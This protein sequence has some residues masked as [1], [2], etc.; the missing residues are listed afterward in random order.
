[1]LGNE[2]TSD[3]QKIF[4]EELSNVFDNMYLANTQNRLRELDN[5]NDVDCKRWPWELV[6]N[7]KDSNSGQTDRKGVDIE[8]DIDDNNNSYTFRHNGSP[9]NVKSL[10]ALMYK[11]SSGKRNDSE[12]TGRFGTG[13]LTTHALSKIVDIKGDI[14]LKNK[15]TN[16]LCTKGFS[17]TMYREGEGE[18]LLNGLKKQKESFKTYKYSFGW[19][20]YKYTTYTQRN[21]EAG[22]MGIQNFKENIAKVMLFCPEINS[23]KL[24]NN[25]KVLTIERGKEFS[26]GNECKKLTLFINDNGNISKRMFLYL[27]INEYNEKLTERFGTKRFLRICCAEELDENNNII[28]D[29]SSPCLFCS[30]PLVGSE[31]HTLPFIINSPDFEP[32][33]ERQAIL[34]DGNE[35]DEKTGKISV[36]GINKMIL[37]RSQSMYR[38]LLQCICQNNIGNRYSLARGLQSIPN[39]TRFFNSN[40]Y[41]NNFILPMRNIL[42]EFPIVWNGTQYFKLTEVYLPEI[43][44]LRSD[45]NYIKKAYKFISQ[46]YK[47]VPTYEDSLLIEK[48]IWKDDNRLNHINIEHCVQYIQKLGNITRLDNSIS[49][50]IWSWLDSFLSFIKLYHSNFL[51]NYA[52]I[53]NMNSNFI[54]QTR[55]LASS[56]SV[57]ENMIECLES[58]GII[59]RNNHIHKSITNFTTGTDHDIDFVVSKIRVFVRNNPSKKLVL[60]HYIPYDEDI[61]FIEK[62]ENIYEFCKTLWSDK[63]SYAKDGTEFPKELWND[64]DERVFQELLNSI[65]NYGQ[66]NNIITI[67]FLN[68]FLNCVSKYYYYYTSYSIIPNKNG[69]F[70]RKDSLYRDDNIPSIF[71]DC[72]KNCFNYDINNELIHDDIT[73]SIKI[74]KRRIYDYYNTLNKYFNMSEQYNY[75]SYNRNNYMPL[76]T[77]K[78]AAKYLIRIIPKIGKTKYFDSQNKQRKLYNLYKNFT[79]SSDEVFEI[80]RNENNEK[81]WKDSN[82]YIIIII[83]EK[84]ENYSTIDNLSSFLRNNDE[85][86]LEYLKDFISF[87]TEGKIIPN[88]NGKLCMKNSLYNEGDWD[89]KLNNYKLI[90]NELKDVAE[91][92]SY[93][94]RNELIHED[95]GRICSES[96]TYKDI[97][98]KI[99]QFIIDNYNNKT[100]TKNLKRA[101][102]YIIETYF[103][104]IGPED[105][106]LY[107]YNTYYKKDDITLNVIYDK[108]TRKNMTELGK[109]FGEDSI[110]K[111]LENE[112]I[113]EGLINGELT[114]EKYNNYKKLEKEYSEKDMQCL[115][116]NS[117]LIKD[118]INGNST[119]NSSVSRAI[120]ISKKLE[121]I[122]SVRSNNTSINSANALNDLIFSVPS[123]SI[124]SCGL[125]TSTI[126]NNNSESV[127]VSFSTGVGSEQ[128]TYYSNTFS[129]VME[130][131]DD[132]DFD[133]PINKKTG[134]CGEAYIYELLKNSGAFKSV[135][136]NM[137]NENG[138]GQFLEYKGKNYYVVPD[139]SHYDILCE[140]NDGRRI[141]IEVKSTVGEFGNKVPFYISKKQIE[142]MKQIEPPN[143]YVLAVVFNVMNYPVHFFMTL[144]SN[145]S[146]KRICC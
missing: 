92:L 114:N 65:Q 40:W 17:L 140:T 81:I 31:V 58:L 93:N 48:M 132:F 50:N 44:N 84:I 51:Y 42:L 52:I 49:K 13:F 130:Y 112:K 85:K 12:S 118:F 137:L 95:I 1:M 57:P 53:P 90:P 108:K 29:S 120:S 143:E 116:K 78:Q 80:E 104:I 110:T 43:S 10:F 36:P 63:M 11:Y 124:S 102:G 101:T 37:N 75:N 38:T 2:E 139:G 99:D 133:N 98:N 18:E 107:F 142:M 66:L 47:S 131:G 19:T 4:D 39:V 45:S 86:T 146:N 87:S 55:E 91:I 16:K 59:W 134:M 144:R 127:C 64:I 121:I 145:L 103:D 15:I 62:R 69:V 35:I 7:S 27:K 46:L 96:I 89:N 122:E 125:S 129:L 128:K 25:G 61:E 82:K 83:K 77:K 68:K 41:Y 8:M 79:K 70:C 32:D 54:K 97:C 76:E 14:I 111:L 113:V 119:N 22:K 135:K 123:P 24:N 21:K 126:S 73:S 60:M 5:P 56:I 106:K 115:L 67:K 26:Y 3:D 71:K 117:K 74:G 136:W 109:K 72:L 20:S 88:Q 28:I 23:V 141:Y 94:I 6:Q 138:Y 30:L 33:S 34:L 105:S 9:F 100:N